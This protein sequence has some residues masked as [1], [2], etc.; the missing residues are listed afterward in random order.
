MVAPRTQFLRK[1]LVATSLSS[2]DCFI[3]QSGN[4]LFIWNGSS[5]TFE[6]QQCAVQIAELLKPGVALKHVNEGTENSAFWFALGGKQSF[7][8][9][10]I[11]QDIVKDPHLY[12][13][14]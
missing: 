5:S 4:S 9:K 11:T 3:L 7:T 2:S 1:R 8:G 14:S 13:F 12:T 10:K 6:Q